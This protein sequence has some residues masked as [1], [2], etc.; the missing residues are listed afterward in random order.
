MGGRGSSE[1]AELQLAG[2]QTDGQ[3]GEAA[4]DVDRR[5]DVKLGCEVQDATAGYRKGVKARQGCELEACGDRLAGSGECKERT[6][7]LRKDRGV[8]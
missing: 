2:A 3:T 4:L 1:V 7:A 5:K 6:G 8:Y